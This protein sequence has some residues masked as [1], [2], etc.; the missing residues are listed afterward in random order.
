M[1]CFYLFLFF[2]H[3][4]LSNC[5]FAFLPSPQALLPSSPLPMIRFPPPLLG[6]EPAS[7]GHQLDMA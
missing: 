6:R 1:T 3:I 2:S 5:S 7:Q 4:L